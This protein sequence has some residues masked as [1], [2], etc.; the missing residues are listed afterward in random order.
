[1]DAA[2]AIIA[3]ATFKHHDNFS[4]MYLPTR[5]YVMHGCSTCELLTKALFMNY[6][7]EGCTALKHFVALKG[8][9]N[10]SDSPQLSGR[11]KSK[12]SGHCPTY[13]T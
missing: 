6:E 1:M 2:L 11:C 3:R 8:L 9:P 10:W 5:L 12:A 7:D 13:M 4:G